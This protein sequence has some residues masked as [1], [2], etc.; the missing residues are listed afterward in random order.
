MFEHLRDA[1]PPVADDATRD[2]VAGRAVRLRRRR[3]LAQVGA[4]IVAVTLVSVGS[5][6]LLN[7]GT[8]SSTGSHKVAA[9]ATHRHGSN[10]AAPTTT[11]PTTT[12]SAQ[13]LGATETRPPVRAPTTTTAPPVRKSPAPAAIASASGYLTG[14]PGYTL[15]SVV[16]HSGGSSFRASAS[17]DSYSVS[18]LAPGSYTVT[19]QAESPPV[20]P[21]NG[22]DIGT[23]AI[24]GN[25]SA[26]LASGPNTVDLS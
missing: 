5:I 16:V 18:G 14:H 3:H 8:A 15:T 10:V 25:S 17:G 20:P 26:I 21:S 9:T 22:V 7:G 6:A 4:A 11:P 23:A 13:V 2:A 1:N 24:A 12:A 19:W